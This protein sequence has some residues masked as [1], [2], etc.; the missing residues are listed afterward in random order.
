[1][2][3]IKKIT[4]REILDSRGNPTVEASAEVEG[5]ISAKAS[6]P[7]G[8]STGIHEAHELRDGNSK[9]FHGIGVLKAVKN[10]ESKIGPAL[11]GLEI[12]NQQKIDES[13]IKLDG[14]KNK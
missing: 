12:T 1:M 8:A 2:S 4:A 5:G 3:K 6:V 14:T 11:K 7:S 10:I 9:R 13:M